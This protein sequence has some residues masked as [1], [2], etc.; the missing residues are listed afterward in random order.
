MCLFVL[1]QFFPP[2]RA[3][4][5]FFVEPTQLLQLMDERSLVFV[6]PAIREGCQPVQTD[7]DADRGMVVQRNVIGNFYRN[8]HKP[9]CGGFGHTG[10]RIL[11]EKRSFSAIFT[12]PNFGTS[13]QWSP[14]LNLS[15][16]R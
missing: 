3:S 14:T 2:M 12:R 15:F 7:I 8:R 4:G 6:L 11:P 16:A 9:P 5:Q 10:E 1:S 13:I